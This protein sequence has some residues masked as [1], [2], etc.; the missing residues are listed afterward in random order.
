M[1]V[2][3]SLLRERLVG[4]LNAGRFEWRKHVLQRLAQHGIAQDAVCEV[5]R[6]GE[7]IEDYPED[8]PYP[9]A[10]FLGWVGENPIHVVVALDEDH[11]WAY[12]ITAY[13]PDLD[14]F[15]PDFRTRRSR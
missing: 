4:A 2:G 5:L 1:V 11:D 15:E 3:K 14:H 8:V 10:L 12:I 9:S 6:S 13:E 7:R